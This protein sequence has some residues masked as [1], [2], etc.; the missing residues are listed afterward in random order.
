ML[1]HI[2]EIR[3]RTDSAETPAVRQPPQRKCSTLSGACVAD[4]NIFQPSP[5]FLRP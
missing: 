4:M 1:L 5:E 2:I 3:Y